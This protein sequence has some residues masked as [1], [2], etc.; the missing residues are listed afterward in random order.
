MTCFIV[1]VK[2]IIRPLLLFFLL[3]I[4]GWGI[5]ISGAFT[6]RA[7]EGKDIRYLM[8]EDRKFTADSLPWGDFKPYEKTIPNFGF[9]DGAVWIRIRVTSRTPRE[10]ILELKNPNLDLVE[11]YEFYKGKPVLMEST[12]DYFPFSHRPVDHRF[13]QF[14][15][16]SP[17]DILLR[18]DNHGDQFYLPMALW[19]KTS[20]AKRDY[21]EQYIFGI[22]YGIVFFVFLLNLFIYL[23]IRER[24]NLYYLLYLLGLVFLQMGLGGHG[25]QYLW[26]DHPYVAN[27]SLPF[28][29]SLTVFFLIRFTQ[30]FLNTAS[31]MPGADR[32]FRWVGVLVLLNALL[33]CVNVQAAYQ[34]SILAINILTFLL[35]I[36]IIPTAIV[37]VRRKFKAARFFLI[38]FIALII[39]VFAFILRNFGAAPSHF[40]TDYSLQIGSSIEVVLLSFAIVDKFKMFKDEA[41]QRLE[42]MNALKSQQN[43]RLEEQVRERT[44]EIASQ[45]SEIEFKNKEILDSIAYARRIQ[46]AILPPSK[47]MR[48]LLPQSFVMYLPKD[49]VAGDFYWVEESGDHLL[50][51]AADCTGHGVPGAMV[52]VVCNN[53]LNRAV[54]EFGMTDPGQVLDKVT[55]LVIDTFARSEDEVRDG[56][57]IALCAWDKKKR[58]LSF[59]GANNP[60]YLV[61]E[62]GLK[63][64]K[65]DRQPVGKYA[66]RKPFTTHSFTPEK[67]DHVY[68]FTDGFPDQFGGPK[69]KKFKY[70]PFKE[71]LIQVSRLPINEQLQTL[72]KTFVNWKGS[73][74]QVDDVC[75]IGVKFVE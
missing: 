74:E 32:F 40:L 13:Y 47:Q 18:I 51:A 8:D 42:E 58:V 27:H 31:V 2:S 17:T 36:A 65:G 25:F 9:Y 19:T 60:L 73:M 33:A 49:I 57:D 75:G 35:N 24:A 44:S 11:R 23:I 10:L 3:P 15:I 28:L 4:T 64:I 45:K 59:A 16:W 61:N 46:Q 54:R 53:A 48:A 55:D 43:I 69:G 72:E 26:P 1:S 56:M 38:A 5:N 70:T 62:N 63:E 7:V 68:I 34:A 71:L 21:D 14:S 37:A 52:S 22:Y 41:V 6:S 30:W 12:G 66:D 20:V 67:G 29:A 50:F 39:S